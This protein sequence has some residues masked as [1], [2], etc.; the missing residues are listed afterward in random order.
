MHAGNGQLKQHSL[1]ESCRQWKS[2]MKSCTR[3]FG[4]LLAYELSWKELLPV[5]LT[6]PYLD[7]YH[8]SQ[9]QN[10]IMM[11]IT[12]ETDRYETHEGQ[13]LICNTKDEFQQPVLLWTL[14]CCKMVYKACEGSQLYMHK[15]HAKEILI[16]C[17]GRGIVNGF[18]LE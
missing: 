3:R 11:N 6:Y 16:Y 10:N 12:Q 14:A 8:I 7:K 18:K 1:S 13:Y 4:H 15:S 2:C 5:L 17:K 9:K